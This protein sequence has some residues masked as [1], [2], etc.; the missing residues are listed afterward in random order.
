[1]NKGDLI[2]AMAER[3]NVTQRSARAC[4][5][6]FVNIICEQVAC[7]GEVNVTGYMK[8]SQVDRK[9]RTARNPKTGEVVQVPATKAVKIQVG[10]R[11][12][13]A[14]RG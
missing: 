5:D 6:A 10:S 8:F 3:A 14:A 13:A 7:G 11:L 4:L 9:P 2:V 12:K 1:M